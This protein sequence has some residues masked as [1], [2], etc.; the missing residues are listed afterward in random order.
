MATCSCVSE[1]TAA[2]KRKVVQ[3]NVKEEEEEE[4]GGGGGGGN[5]RLYQMMP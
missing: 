4:E 1:L 2:L 5:R 3:V